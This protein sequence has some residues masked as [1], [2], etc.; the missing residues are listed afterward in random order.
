MARAKIIEGVW[1][2]NVTWSKDNEWR[3]DIFKSTLANPNLETAC[4]ILQDGRRILITAEELKRVLVG[5]ADHFDEKIWGP[6]N[7]NPIS[8]TLNGANVAMTVI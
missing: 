4:F 6:F 7:L 3:T 5:G 2:R 1:E 8:K